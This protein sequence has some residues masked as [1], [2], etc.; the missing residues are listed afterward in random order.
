VSSGKFGFETM[1]GT[2]RVVFAQRNPVFFFMV[3]WYVDGCGG[4]QICDPVIYSLRQHTGITRQNTQNMP[5]SECQN[6]VDVASRSLGKTRVVSVVG[7][8]Y[9][10]TE[11]HSPVIY[12]L[13]QHSSDILILAYFVCFVLLFQYVLGTQSITV[14]ILEACFYDPRFFRAELYERFHLRSRDQS[15]KS[16]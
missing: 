8:I 6:C 1:V 11:V 2:I 12:S 7:V 14:S 15:G 13:R 3:N 5:K 4:E 10:N 9:F 16:V